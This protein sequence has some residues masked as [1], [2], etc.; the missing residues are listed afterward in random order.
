MQRIFVMGLVVMAACLGEENSTNDKLVLGEA[1][2]NAPAPSEPPP[3]T[4]RPAR[5]VPTPP[6]DGAPEYPIWNRTAQA[7]VT[8]VHISSWLPYQMVW[9]R[10]TF[11]DGTSQTA[12]TVSTGYD[13]NTLGN[14]VIGQDSVLSG[15]HG[16]VT[17]VSIIPRPDQARQVNYTW[18]FVRDPSDP[19][20]TGPIDPA[21]R[22]RGPYVDIALVP[23][24]PP[25]TPPSR[26]SSPKPLPP[27]QAPSQ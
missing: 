13:P 5:S 14:A 12:G 6:P 2:P 3:Q 4:T 9:F 20:G 19:Q 10:V 21:F 27:P 23:A 18:I 15:T 8:G 16:P 25:G 22:G 11:S 7:N 24:P 17:A 1:G 26:G